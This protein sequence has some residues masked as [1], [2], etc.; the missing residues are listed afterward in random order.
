MTIQFTHEQPESAG[1]GSVTFAFA[2]ETSGVVPMT[3]A[4]QV[5]WRPITRYGEHNG[6]FNL[7]LA[8]DVPEPRDPARP[9]TL[10]ELLLILRRV[11]ERHESL[12]AHFR[13][14]PGGPTMDVAAAGEFAVVL[15]EADGDG[16]RAV[17]DALA[18]ELGSPAVDYGAEWP[19]RFGVVS[20]LGVPAHLVLSISHMAADVSAARLVFLELMD[21]MARPGDLDL[22]E[23][24]GRSP[25]EQSAFEQSDQGLRRTG[26]ALSFWRR[27]LEAM[28]ATMFDF[29][30]AELSGPRCHRLRFESP[31]LAV[32][33][34]RLADSAQVSVSTVLL[35]GTALALSALTGQSTAAIQLIASGRL[36]EDRREMVA[37]C[38]R[39]AMFLMDFPDGALPELLQQVHRTALA[40]YFY[41]DVA[42]DRFEQM[43]AEVE[44]ERGEH[45]DRDVFFSDTRP[46]DRWDHVRGAEISYAQA[47]ELAGKSTISLVSTSDIKDSEVFMTVDDHPVKDRC[48]LTLLHDNTFVPRPAAEQALRGI[49]AFF[50]EAAYDDA[51][52]TG[53]FA[54]LSGIKPLW[55]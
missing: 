4:Q 30:R 41:A 25:L 15:R 38:T 35:T 14:A 8:V 28:P 13:D 23:L 5:I 42:P 6:Y 52:T 54:E 12:R 36:D 22:P 21:L 48:S 17:A 20:R 46:L 26:K 24:A 16:S 2:A 3:W 9:L 47:R 19:I 10:D 31:A 39:N 11:V 43:L 18:Q 45:L 32:A 55:Q 29:E 27:R 50:I 7:K 1:Q 37:T 40:A 44:A 51:V 33:A 49:E 53:R 34:D